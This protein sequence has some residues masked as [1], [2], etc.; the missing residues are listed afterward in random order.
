MVLKMR[1]AAAVVNVRRRAMTLMMK[2]CV[3]HLWLVYSY[4]V[5]NR[6]EADAGV[7]TVENEMSKKPKLWHA[8]GI[9]IHY[10]RT[11]ELT[12]AFLIHCHRRGHQ[13]FFIK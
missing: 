5:Y 8:N 10:N 7:G 3:H 12:S 6:S 9:L 13:V 2:A 1:K 11:G 4:C